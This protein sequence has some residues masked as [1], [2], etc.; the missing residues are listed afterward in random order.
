MTP[1][2]TVGPYE[3]I[4]EWLEDNGVSQAKLARLMGVS[5]KHIT[6]LKQ[7][8]TLTIEIARKLEY[9][10]GIPVKFWINAEATYKADLARL[11]EAKA[12][13]KVDIPFSDSALSE[14]RSRGITTSTRQRGQKGFL[15]QQLMQLFRVGSWESLI[16]KLGS[17]RELSI[18]YRQTA[19]ADYNSVSIWLELGLRELEEL[20]PIASFNEAGLK[21]LV[22]E[23]RQLT[24][25]PPEH[26]GGRLV[27]ML[28][29]VGVHLIYVKDLPGTGTFGATRWIDGK[30]VIQ[31]SL[32][33]KREDIF[34]FT[35]FHEIGHVLLHG[36]D[37]VFVNVDDAD[38][39]VLEKDADNYASDVLLPHEA[40][41]ALRPGITLSEVDRIAKRA[42]IAPGVVVGRC[43]HE[44]YLAHQVGQ[45]KIRRLEITH[46]D[47][48]A[49]S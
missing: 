10:T 13:E 14:L 37:G 26:F 5:A 9:V 36:R 41:S 49:G 46:A 29:S 45:W 2:Y 21:Q 4:E 42:G 23:I 3:Y 11:E 18:A 20:S 31:L 47:D 48:G 39:P 6:K 27:E 17:N 22:P 32:R 8:D 1:N 19:T 43:H 25:S 40:V 12:L 38:K 16:M 33:N 7:G 34:W 28:N 35:L 15:C 24:L 30:P 44:K